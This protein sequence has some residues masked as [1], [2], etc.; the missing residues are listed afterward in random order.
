MGPTGKISPSVMCVDFVKL[1]ESIRA[2]ER[3]GVE[4]LHVDIMDGRF[5]PNFTLGPDFV[6]AL[7]EITDIPL[8]Y[9]LMVQEPDAHI[10]S[11][12]IKPGDIVTVHQEA[13]THLQ[14]TLQL[15]RSYGAKAAVALN[16]AT[17]ILSIEDVLEDLDMVLIMTVNPG[18]AGQKLVP[19]TLRKIERLKK[20]LS[21]AGYGHIEVEVDGNVS[22]ENAVKM[23]ASGADIFVAGTSSIFRRGEDI[24]TL[25]ERFRAC[26]S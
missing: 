19:S 17:P 22:F 24:L 11:F 7:R 21:E 15:I 3:A 2:L 12:P 8:D 1:E 18:F 13:C 5:V 10:G 6:K 16:P 14:R 23:R 25:T 20:L 9:H 26:I 4:Y